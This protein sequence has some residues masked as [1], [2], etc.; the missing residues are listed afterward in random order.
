MMSTRTPGARYAS[1]F[2]VIGDPHF[3]MD[4][5]NDNYCTEMEDYFYSYAGDNNILWTMCEAAFEKITTFPQR[6]PN[7]VPLEGDSAQRINEII[8]FNKNIDVEIAQ[9]RKIFWENDSKMDA[10]WAKICTE[11]LA[12]MTRG[13]PVFERCRKH[14]ESKTL[15]GRDLFKAYWRE[16]HHFSKNSPLDV[17]KYRDAIKDA[18]DK[19]GIDELFLVQNVNCGRLRGIEQR[20][21]GT[22]NPIKCVPTDDEMKIYLSRSLTNDAAKKIR[23]DLVNPLKTGYTYQDAV[24]EITALYR[25]IPT[26]DTDYVKKCASTKVMITID[27][28]NNNNHN[29]STDGRG[30]T[31]SQSASRGPC[32]VC[33]G[34]GHIK[35]ECPQCDRCKH[36]FPSVSMRKEHD[37][38]EK[39]KFSR[40]SGKK[41]KDGPKSDGG[42]W[43]KK[44]GAKGNSGS[45]SGNTSFNQPKKEMV[46]G[47]LADSL[48]S[49]LVRGGHDL[50]DAADKAGVAF[51]NAVV[52]RK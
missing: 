13:G 8:E 44:A 38:P 12:T 50:G 23:D 30:L 22:V 1:Q 20:T 32:F 16:I 28:T 34:L 10:G 3:K 31:V 2:T 6:P 27:S 40:D 47:K 41:R 21:A 45:A 36:I 7:L 15:R 24:D 9:R 33:G 25:S 52:N 17:E 29:V 51:I 49:F 4:E 5:K 26:Y 39:G 46:C 14:L 42:T 11:M 35:A 48:R 19:N 37:C 18:D 43:K